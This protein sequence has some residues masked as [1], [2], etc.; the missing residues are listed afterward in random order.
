MKPAEEAIY[1]NKMLELAASQ[2][3]KP[4]SPATK[5]TATA[6]KRAAVTKAAAKSAGKPAKSSLS[7]EDFEDLRMHI[8][9]LSSSN[10]P[11][12]V[13]SAKPVRFRTRRE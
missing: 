12:L 9:D 6:G 10:E 4:A 1:R 5:D 7:Q 3:R 11:V 13:L 2:L 8:F